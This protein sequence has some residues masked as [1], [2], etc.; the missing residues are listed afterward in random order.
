ML[1][2]AIVAAFWWAGVPP[3]RPRSLPRGAVFLWGPHLGIPKPKK[4]LWLNCWQGASGRDQGGLSQQNGERI[5]QG[6]YLSYKQAYPVAES[7]RKIDAVKSDGLCLWVD[8][9][10]VPLVYLKNG[11]ILIP[12]A[13][14]VE[15]AKLLAQE[16]LIT[17]CWPAS[18][19]SAGNNI[20]QLFCWK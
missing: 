2:V 7:E 14:Y 8:G 19:I 1:I 10:L 20:P 4:G 6:E 18:T 12:A 5:Y 3:R 15:G 13:R 17:G 16:A 9:E 11:Q